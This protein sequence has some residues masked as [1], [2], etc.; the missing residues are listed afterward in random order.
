M[1]TVYWATYPEQGEQSISELRYR[2]PESLLKDIVPADFFGQ[3][4]GRC[5]SILDECRNT[6]KIK[7]PVDLHLTFNDDF[8]SCNSKYKQELSFISQLVGA[9][10]PER[11]VQMSSPTYLY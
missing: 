11:V 5:P 7:S 6:F 10:G 4:A 2:P 1:K 3:M 9:I 8:T